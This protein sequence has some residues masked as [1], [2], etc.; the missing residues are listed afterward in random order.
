MTTEK[1]KIK[2]KIYSNY[3]NNFYFA[4]IP[5]QDYIYLKH[6][7]PDKIIQRYIIIGVQH[8]KSISLS[9]D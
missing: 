8:A 4:E 6:K 7:Y 9:V 1:P 2:L 5:Y 3:S